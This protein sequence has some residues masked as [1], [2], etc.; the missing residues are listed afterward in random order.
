[1]ENRQHVSPALEDERVERCPQPPAKM[2]LERA[3][4]MANGLEGLQSGTEPNGRS[5]PTDSA[6]GTL[7]KQS[8]YAVSGPDNS[9]AQNA[10]KDNFKDGYNA[11]LSVT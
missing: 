9:V 4:A 3:K 5:R 6:L 8:P 7:P 1:M 2:A 11:K 10:C